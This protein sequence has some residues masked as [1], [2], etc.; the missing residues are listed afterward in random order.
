MTTDLQTDARLTGDSA[1]C[2][3]ALFC[4]RKGGDDT[5][6][7]CLSM[8]LLT[9]ALLSKGGQNHDRGLSHPAY[10]NT[11]NDAAQ[12]GRVWRVQYGTEAES[13]PCLKHVC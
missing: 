8:A 5:M 7:T 9:G 10:G 2:S 13:R 12:A 6:T 4:V 3:T 11:Q 1:V